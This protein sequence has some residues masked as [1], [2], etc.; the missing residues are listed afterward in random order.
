MS[1]IKLQNVN[2]MNHGIANGPMDGELDLGESG[3]L[4]ES[5]MMD[6]SGILN[7]FIPGYAYEIIKFEAFE[8]RLILWWGR[9]LVTAHIQIDDGTAEVL[10]SGDLGDPIY[11]LD[12]NH[13]V[14][15]NVS[16]GDY[17]VVGIKSIATTLNFDYT[18]YPCG[19]DYIGT[20]E[21]CRTQ[22]YNL[23]VPVCVN[24]PAEFY[25]KG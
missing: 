5:G 20:D 9:T 17:N 14:L 16:Q 8:V 18:H 7:D 1:K 6:D 11:N 21:E 25:L 15:H 2:S 3:I 10:T 12:E 23:I 13:Y 4:D 22:R 19:K 24:I